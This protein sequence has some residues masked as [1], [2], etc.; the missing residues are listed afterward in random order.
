MSI[1]LY[2]LKEFAFANHGTIALQ[3]TPGLQT[4]IALKLSTP[5]KEVNVMVTRVAVFV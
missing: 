2:Y 4:D 1:F 3:V 5:E